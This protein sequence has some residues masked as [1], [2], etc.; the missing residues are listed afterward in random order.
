MTMMI[1]L[2]LIKAM[3]VCTYEGMCAYRIFEY[4]NSVELIIM[5][6]LAFYARNIKSNLNS[7]IIGT[8]I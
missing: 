6:V 2:S 3:Y 7:R 4:G 1:L 5:Y 8:L